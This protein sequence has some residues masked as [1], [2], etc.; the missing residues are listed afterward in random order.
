MQGS[1]DQASVTDPPACQPS[2][3]LLA[4]LV[5]IDPACCLPN[6]SARSYPPVAADYPSISLYVYISSL[7]LCPPPASRSMDLWT[8]AYRLEG[9]DAVAAT[10]AGASPGRFPDSYGP[11]RGKDSSTFNSCE[12]LVIWEVSAVRTGGRSDSMQVIIHLVLSNATSL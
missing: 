8:L 9:A 4:R 10:A 5:A 6:L 7:S 1:R 11:L 12:K 2:F 3:Q